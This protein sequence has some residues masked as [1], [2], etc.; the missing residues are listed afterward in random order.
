[1][2]NYFYLVHLFVWFPQLAGSGA[3][4]LQPLLSF[5]HHEPYGSSRAAW[6]GAVAKP[7]EAATTA[8]AA[9]AAATTPSTPGALAAA[10]AAAGSNRGL[11]A[12][13]ALLVAEWG[14]RQLLSLLSRVM[15]R[16]CKADLALLPPCYKK[17]S[18]CAVVLVVFLRFVVLTCVLQCQSAAASN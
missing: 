4:H 8:F 7:L 11:C 17:V 9:A 3:S 10:G 6:D 12:A 2:H 1:L 5:L 14:R 13:A 16:S 15:I 18:L